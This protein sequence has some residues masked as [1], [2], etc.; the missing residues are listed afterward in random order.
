[1]TSN[2]YFDLFVVG[3]HVNL[4][5]LNLHLVED[6]LWHRKDPLFRT[7]RLT[8]AM[9]PNDCNQS[10]VPVVAILLKQATVCYK[11]PSQERQS[12]SHGSMPPPSKAIILE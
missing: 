3:V 7:R 2:L 12:N 11:Q 6:I 1:L 8:S 4:G 10:L 5:N 9:M